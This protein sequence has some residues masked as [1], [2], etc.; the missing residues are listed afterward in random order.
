MLS[1]FQSKLDL[2]H[3]LMRKADLH[4]LGCHVEKGSEMHVAC[5]ADHCVDIAD[6]LK[7]RS[8]ARKIADINPIVAVGSAGA[9]NFV[10]RLGFFDD[11]SPDGAVG[12]VTRIFIVT[13]IV[14]DLGAPSSR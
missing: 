2:A 3:E 13:V 1:S 7:Q 10:A 5:G 8:N 6:L 14:L 9:D 4:L 12:A 11:G